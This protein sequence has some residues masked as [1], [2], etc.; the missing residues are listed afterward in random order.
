MLEE[1]QYQ[2]MEDAISENETECALQKN[3]I[4]KK[5][6]SAAS[7]E[8]ASGEKKEKESK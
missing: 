3:R 2:P 6:K 7:V 5:D 8:K 1:G 4:E